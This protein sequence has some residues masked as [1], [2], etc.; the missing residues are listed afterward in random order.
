[1]APVLV[2]PLHIQEGRI[3]TAPFPILHGGPVSLQDKLLGS[4]LQAV[5]RLHTNQA[6]CVAGTASRLH[7]QL[8]HKCTGQAL[9][10]C[11][12]SCS[13]K[14]G[15]VKTRCRKAFTVC[16][17]GCWYVSR[18]LPLRAGESNQAHS[19]RPASQ[20]ASLAGAYQTEP[21]TCR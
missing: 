8:C 4:S 1:M 15:Q 10:A 9:L 12:A 20:Q 16:S 18:N 6:E 17:G 3:L 7:V 19:L 5:V 2:V 11:T 21:C 14:P 13:C